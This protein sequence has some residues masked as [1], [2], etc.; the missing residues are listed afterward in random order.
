[1]QSQKCPRLH[2]LCQLLQPPTYTSQTRSVYDCPLYKAEKEHTNIFATLSC[3]NTTPL[4]RPLH[5]QCHFTLVYNPTNT[6]N[7]NDSK[8]Y[9][10]ALSKSITACLIVLDSLVPSYALPP[11]SSSC[12][13]F[14]DLYNTFPLSLSAY[15]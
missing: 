3:I 5:F 13:L 6:V 9:N 12:V 11:K 4:P 7:Y 15:P 10:V 1:M 14:P 8:I 2:H